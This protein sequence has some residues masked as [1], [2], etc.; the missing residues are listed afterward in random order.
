MIIV[1][2]SVESSSENHQ[3]LL[4]LSIQHVHRSREEPGC[5]SH[6]VSIDAENGNRL[7]FFEEWADMPAL[8]QHFSVPASRDFAARIRELASSAPELRMF[9]AEPRS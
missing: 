4:K 1:V 3:E 5:I 7:N 6:N 9:E 8:Q 2:G